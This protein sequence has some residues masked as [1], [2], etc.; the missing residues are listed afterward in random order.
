MSY[1]KEYLSEFDTKISDVDVI[2]NTIRLGDIPHSHA[3][4]D[5]AKKLLKYNPEYTMQND[6][7]EA[8]KWY[9][10]TYYK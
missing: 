5:K 8:V 6:L 7:K 10:K 4:I 3:N 1:L 2:Y 9:W